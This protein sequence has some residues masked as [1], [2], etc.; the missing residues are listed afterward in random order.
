LNLVLEGLMLAEVASQKK[1]FDREITIPLERW[2]I[3]LVNMILPKYQYFYD[4][5]I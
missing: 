1:R 4:P 2:G 3:L 5:R